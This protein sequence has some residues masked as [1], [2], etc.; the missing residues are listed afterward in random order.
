M[1]L[2]LG[3]VVLGALVLVALCYAQ[4]DRLPKGRIW[5]YLTVA[6]MFHNAVPFLL[7]AINA[8]N[9][10]WT[11]PVAIALG[12]DRTLSGPR[13]AGLGGVVLIFA[14]WQADGLVGWGALACVAAAVS[15]GFVFVC[16]NK[17]LSGTGSSPVALA[18]A[19]MLPRPGPCC[20]APCYCTEA[21]K[22]RAYSWAW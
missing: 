18:G 14:A 16:E 8:T 13:I 20:T 9:P 19:Q 17:Y 1:Q 4:R 11:V 15:Y 21:L 5:L 10:L 3:R 22:A 2:V 7:F 6:A 12:I